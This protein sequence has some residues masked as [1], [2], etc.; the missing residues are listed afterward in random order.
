MNLKLFSLVWT[1]TFREEKRFIEYLGFTLFEFVVFTFACEAEKEEEKWKIV[2][3]N[4]KGKEIY[5]VNRLREGRNWNLFKCYT[6]ILLKKWAFF[7]DWCA[8]KVLRKRSYFCSFDDEVGSCS[9]KHVIIHW[10]V[11]K[12]RKRQLLEIDASVQ[13]R[14]YWLLVVNEWVRDVCASFK[15]N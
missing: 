15:L 12:M 1:T 8:I 11:E 5:T 7:L 2:V 3:K 9:H 4:D 10:T 14:I 6:Y 13:K